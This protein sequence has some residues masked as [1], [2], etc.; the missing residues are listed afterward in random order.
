MI[1]AGWAILI[2]APSTM[3]LIPLTVIWIGLGLSMARGLAL[4]PCP[5]CGSAFCDAPGMPY[6]YALFASDCQKCGL[7]THAGQRFQ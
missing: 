6:W 4:S 3:V 7:S 2:M 5:R 1:P